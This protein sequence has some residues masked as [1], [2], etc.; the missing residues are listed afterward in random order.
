MTS[1]A[2][3]STTSLPALTGLRGVA[4]LWVVLFHVQAFFGPADAIPASGR[5]LIGHG[6]VAV[7]LFFILSGFVLMHVHGLEFHSIEADAVGRF[8]AQRALRIYPTA[9]VVLL[10]ILGLILIDPGFAADPQSF[11]PADLTW[12][13]FLVTLALAT[14]WTATPIQDWNL[15]VWSL[16]VEIIGYLAFPWIARAAGQVATPRAAACRGLGCIALLTMVNAISGRTDVNDYGAFGIARMAGGFVCGAY[17]ARAFHLTPRLSAR[18]ASGLALVAAAGL[19]LAC[20]V[21]S[22]MVL[23]L[24]SSA[25]LVI[26]LAYGAG[27]VSR[28][29][30]TRPLLWLGRISFPLYLVHMEPIKWLA[31]RVRISPPRGDGLEGLL[32]AC[33]A[34]CLIAAYLL[35]VLV[36]RPTHRL[37]RRIV[38]PRSFPALARPSAEGYAS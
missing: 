29:L 38:L 6:W 24:V 5:F 30:S 26:A 8:L 4:A 21:P 23:S 34:A 31:Y 17:L 28:C 15:P 25:L 3:S 33:V 32:V 1:R 10:L 14:R 36:E 2:G 16:S 9:T 12:R 22:L 37:A 35:H 18:S 20:A 27:G 13:T 7:D 11:A 19:C